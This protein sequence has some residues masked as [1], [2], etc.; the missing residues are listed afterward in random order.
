MSIINF[1]TISSEIPLKKQGLLDCQDFYENYDEFDR[2]SKKAD[3]YFD[4]IDKVN[5]TQSVCD[6]YGFDASVEAL[7]GIELIEFAEQHPNC[8]SLSALAIVLICVAAAAVIAL[9]AWLLYKL[10]KKSDGSSSAADLEKKIDKIAEKVGA[11]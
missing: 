10:F 7:V 5:T 6:K 3:S 2:L 8:E 4:L 11:K 9:I 1:N